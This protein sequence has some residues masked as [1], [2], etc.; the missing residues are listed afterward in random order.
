VCDI[1]CPLQ[2]AIHAAHG[3]ELAVGA[4]RQ[5]DRYTLTGLNRHSEDI[6]IKGSG[7]LSVGTADDQGIWTH[8]ESI[9]CEWLGSDDPGL[10]YV[11]LLLDGMVALGSVVRDDELRYSL[12]DEESPKHLADQSVPVRTTIRETQHVT[13]RETTQAIIVRG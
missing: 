13:E 10:Q 8:N 2:C 9:R 7:S 11:S 5:E 1:G 12:A 4:Y 3:N 6:L